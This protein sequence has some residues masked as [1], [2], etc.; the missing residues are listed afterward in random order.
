MLR[1]TGRSAD[2]A[3]GLLPL[4]ERGA[5]REELLSSVNVEERSLAVAALRVLSVQGLVIE[6][7]PAGF[8]SYLPLFSTPDPRIASRERTVLVVGSGLLSTTCRRL[9]Q[10]AGATVVG[11]KSLGKRLLAELTKFDLVVFCPPHP[12]DQRSL[13][14]N[15]AALA[16]RVRWLRATACQQMALVGPAVL[17]YS[18]AC[19]R[20]LMQ[21]SGAFEGIGAGVTHELW[22]RLEEDELLAQRHCR[23]APPVLVI[24]GAMAAWEAIRLLLE[25]SA[26]LTVDALWSLDVVSGTTRLEPVLRMPRCDAC[27]VKGPSP[28][29]WTPIRLPPDAESHERMS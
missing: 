17:P 23:A 6:G 8:D 12:L 28:T 11:A 13:A 15:E 10:T 19:Y 21:R 4:L 16:Q 14:L 20:C 18:S 26:S 25:E 5:S 22:A 2:A 7:S 9:I 3:L 24:A 29:L 1:I 27:G